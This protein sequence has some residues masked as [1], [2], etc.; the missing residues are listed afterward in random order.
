MRSLR[1]TWSGDYNAA[2]FRV[3]PGHREQISEVKQ[4]IRITVT[5]KVGIRFSL[6]YPKDNSSS[7]VGSVTS[8]L[9]NAG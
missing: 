6:S 3:A 8:K 7:M 4:Q 9:L 2:A 5:T 1:F